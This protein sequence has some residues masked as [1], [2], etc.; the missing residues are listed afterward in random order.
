MPEETI[1]YY[2]HDYNAET[3]KEEL[4]NWNKDNAEVIKEDNL[5]EFI[6]VTATLFKEGQTEKEKST[7]TVYPNAIKEAVIQYLIKHRYLKSVVDVENYYI[8]L[9]RDSNLMIAVI[10]METK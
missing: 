9:D 4:A 10:E 3:A 7:F 2:T 6:K 1:D 5:E 8:E